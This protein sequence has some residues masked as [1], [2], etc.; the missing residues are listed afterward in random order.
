MILSLV[1]AASIG[2][3]DATALQRHVEFLANPKLEGRMTGSPGEREAT[4]YCANYFKEIGALPGG[5]GGTYFQDFPV[6]YGGT[7]APN[8]DLR[9]KLSDGSELA[10]ADSD[11]SAVYGSAENQV[12]TGS[13]VFAGEGVVSDQRDDFRGLDVGGKFVMLFPA[14]PRQNPSNAV[15]AKAAEDRG[16]VGVIFAGPTEDGSH[17]VMRTTRQRGIGR[18]S[19]LVALAV[20]ADVFTKLLGLDYN[21]ARTA[22]KSGK[23]I[24]PKQT[25]ASITAKIEIQP[26]RVT[27]RNVIAVLPGNDPN[28]RNQ[29]IVIGAHIDHVGWGDVGSL[30]G[31]EKIHFGA[32]D[33]AS[34]T[35]MVLEIA[36]HFAKSK[37]NRRTLVFQLYSGEELGLI[38]S[39]FFTRNP[40]I[41]LDSIAA[42][43]N[44][45]MVGNYADG[46]LEISGVGSSPSWPALIDSVKE[47]AEIKSVEGVRPDSDQWPFAN[48]GVPVLFLHTGLHPRYHRHTDTAEFI[49]YAGMQIVGNTAIE[50]IKRIDAMAEMPAFKRGQTIVDRKAP[51]TDTS[52]RNMGR[53]VRVGLIPEYGDGGPG[54]LLSG[55]ADNS[56]AQRAGLQG[57]DRII[58]WGTTKIESI[59]D[60]QE[61]FTNSE[62]GKAVEVTILRDG[63]EMK[64][65]VVPEAI[66]DLLAA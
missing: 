31:S 6:T 21:E 46:K 33:N 60:I 10:I 52:D 22:A 43:I 19:R 16:A 59:E 65:T 53:R 12:A 44:L 64:M 30:S 17:S 66:G 61:I 20:S 11:W 9:I 23:V 56:P 2:S 41:A 4:E 49:D 32:D 29:H 48:Q 28:L 35:A 50:I 58:M 47:T 7:K 40:T 3:I 63:K 38:G 57:G 8:S 24:A 36:K 62:A 51:A 25:S 37:S 45:D 26:N 54:L 55:V 18:D 13:L 14:A 42:M 15:R 1:L 27:G 34:G 5:V 39:T